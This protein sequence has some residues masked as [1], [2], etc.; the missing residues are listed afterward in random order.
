[1]FTLFHPVYIYFFLPYAA[2][3][4]CCCVIPSSL[5][6]LQLPLP[7]LLIWLA[8][9]LSLYFS[10]CSCRWLHCTLFSFRISYEGRFHRLKWFLWWSLKQCWLS[11]TDTLRNSAWMQHRETV[12]ATEML[13]NRE[14]IARQVVSFKNVA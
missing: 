13:I 4:C 5:L 9:A 8:L 14:A 11:C 10:S 12:H 7:S 3:L 2:N 6:L 1:M